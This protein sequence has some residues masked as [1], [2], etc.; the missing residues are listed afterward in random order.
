MGSSTKYN[1]SRTHGRGRKAGRGKGLKGGS[2]NSGSFKHNKNKKTKKQIIKK[3][4]KTT[5]IT[6][7]S[8][9]QLLFFTPK[10][11]SSKL[12]LKDF[13]FKKII[14]SKIIA[15]EKIKR[16]KNIDLIVIKITKKAIINLKKI[17]KNVIVA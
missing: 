9:L 1:H 7:N 10:I 16:F 8:F 3:K 11:I 2:G 5:V 13:G 4:I 6:I 12:F 15:F 17:F 14:N